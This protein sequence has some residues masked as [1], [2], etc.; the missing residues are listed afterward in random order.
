MAWCK[1]TDVTL[2][3]WFRKKPFRAFTLVELL[4]V[5]A[6]IG[7]L[8]AL[9]LPAVNAARES[10]RRTDCAHRMKQL[11]LAALNY[12]SARQQFPTGYL[13]QDDGKPIDLEQ[14]AQWI[15]MLA[16]ILP[17]MEYNE[18]R[19]RIDT[20]MKVDRFAPPFWRDD[21][22]WEVA[23]WNISPF[24]CPSATPGPA[25]DMNFVMWGTS[26]TDEQEGRITITLQAFGLPAEDFPLGTTNYLGCMGLAGIIGNRGVDERT[27]I[28]TTRSKT[29]TQ[30]IRDGMSN[31][32]LLGEAV[33]T[34]AKNKGLLHQF[35]WIGTGT[36]PVMFGLNPFEQSDEEG[37]YLA[38]WTQFSSQHND[39]VQFCF[40]DGSVHPIRKNVDDSTLWA[41]AGMQEGESV[42][43]D[44]L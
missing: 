34:V 44:S 32:L 4:V 43:L 6:I 8:V 37:E 38:H 31:T 33:G 40:A 12:E 23:H 30:K 18:V 14:D 10:A 13:G 29:T 27:G 11:G 15:G 24:H 39:I 9:L 36:L 26:L 22:T 19:E 25:M 21:G 16:Y 2:T 5:I 1:T 28:F 3:R 42:N 7:I 35:T 17:Y 41:L 20:D